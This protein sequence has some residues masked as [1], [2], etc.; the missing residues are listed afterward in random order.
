[1]QDPK[2]PNPGQN[3]NFGGVPPHGA[4]P[5]EKICPFCCNKIAANARKCL[6]CGEYLDPGLRAHTSQNIIINNS[7]NGSAGMGNQPKPLGTFS[8]LGNILWIIFGGIFVAL[9]YFAAGLV[10][11][12]TIILIPFGIPLIKL[13]GL[14]L[15]PFGKV[16]V[17]KEKGVGCL[18]MGMNVLWIFT[19]GW[20]IAFSHLFLAVCFFCT[21]IGIPFAVQHMKLMQL[22]FMPFGFTYR[23]A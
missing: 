21:I 15:L 6:F 16:I 7:N 11:C 9:E 23:N 1:M 20:I 8:I 12:C 22:A 17:T 2:N 14:A 4:A 3:Q 10:L 18:A 19:G 13:S 5:K